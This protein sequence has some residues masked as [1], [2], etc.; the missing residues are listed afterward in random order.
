MR[1][2]VFDKF[3]ASS[4][5]RITSL[6]S[7]DISARIRGDVDITA[8]LVTQIIPTLVIAFLELIC[9][10]VILMWF[11]PYL[12]GVLAFQI[13]VYIILLV[14]TWPRLQR[15][16]G[17]I[18]KCSSSLLDLIIETFR[19][20]RT[21]KLFNAENHHSEMMQKSGEDLVNN[22]LKAISL[23]NKL[24]ACRQVT[25]G[26]VW[27]VTM[28]IGAILVKRA[29]ITIGTLVA[30]Y[31]I[32]SRV[33]K[34]LQ[35]CYESI[36]KIA[37]SKVSVG[38]LQEILEYPS[39]NNTSAEVKKIV[40]NHEQI[41][42]RNSDKGIVKLENVAFGHTNNDVFIK[43][44]S[45]TA[46]SAKITAITG[47]SG[48]GKTTL[49]S[50]IAGLYKP[51]KGT[52]FVNGIVI[53]D[54][55]SNKN[56]GNT[57]SVALLDQE[58]FLFK[59]SI[60]DNLKYGNNDLDMPA[61][62]KACKETGIHEEIMNLPKAYETVL[63]EDIIDLSTGQKQRLSLARVFI[64]NSSVILLDEVTAFIDKKSSDLIM[65]SLQ[66]KVGDKTIIIATHD[67]YVLEY[68]TKIYELREGILTHVS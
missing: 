63:G 9:M 43:N 34:P 56:G 40:V 20:I 30:F 5:S 2:I 67:A 18:R 49:L 27:F 33:S 39:T 21:I 35:I 65:G 1:N 3:Q 24:Q 31:T 48:S 4:L 42:S 15:V 55:A 22:T 37:E 13:P 62:I 68:C 51:T 58:P 8:N 66:Q 59:C 19:G 25:E 7:G 60:F 47:P 41:T 10:T 57:F 46:E 45:M 64:R 26:I 6:A 32:V 17:K 28:L 11:S 54:D 23:S 12:G 44:A 52:I 16:T 53:P 29:E 50:L 38:R 36:N 14:V 61:A